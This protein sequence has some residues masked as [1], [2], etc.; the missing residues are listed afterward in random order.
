M[1][2]MEQWAAAKKLY[3]SVTVPSAPVRVPSQRPLVRV[4]SQSC[5]DDNEVKP[6]AVQRSPGIY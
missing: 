3:A 5:L 1:L 6:E 2:S 4:S